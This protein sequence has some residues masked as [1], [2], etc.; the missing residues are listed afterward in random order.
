MIRSY[1]T[2]ALRERVAAAARHRCGYCLTIEAV[3]GSAMEIEHIVPEALGGATE[4][5]NLWLAC[6][7]CNGRK[8]MRV[9]GIDPAT[10]ETARFFDPRRQNWADHFA[11][12]EGGTRIIGLTPAG[13][14][15]VTALELNWAIL[16][17]ARRVW[18][19]AGWHPRRLDAVPAEPMGIPLG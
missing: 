13:R 14:A 19:A 9:S 15:T 12:T 17:A 4:E 2:A 16:V 18:V 7:A 10:G 6:P 11:W 3:V 5:D 8:S 1:V